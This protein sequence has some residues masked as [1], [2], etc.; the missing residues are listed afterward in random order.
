MN[1]KRKKKMPR[2]MYKRINDRFLDVRFSGVE[3]AINAQD[4]SKFKE[5]RKKLNGE[6]FQTVYGSTSF[7]IKKRKN[8]EPLNYRDYDYIADLNNYDENEEYIGHATLRMWRHF[9]GKKHH[10]LIT[11]QDIPEADKYE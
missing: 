1:K 2:P 9:R 3:N 10:Y 6:T 4:D 8:N 5:K 7:Q 11:I